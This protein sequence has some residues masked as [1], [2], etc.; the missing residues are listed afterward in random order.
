M[1]QNSSDPHPFLQLIFE[2]LRKP[3]ESPFCHVTYTWAIAASY[4]PMLKSNEIAH[5]V[6]QDVAKSLIMFFSCAFEA[7][8]RDGLESK[9][10][11]QPCRCL[12][13]FPGREL[14]EC[15]QHPGPG[16]ELQT[17]TLWIDNLASFI[18]LVAR[19]TDRLLSV[20]QVS[21]SGEV[22]AWRRRTAE[23]VEKHSDGLGQSFLI[24]LKFGQSGDAQIFALF[25]TMLEL[26]SKLFQQLESSEHLRL[27]WADRFQQ[28]IRTES[29]S[30]TQIRSPRIDL[31]FH[32]AGC[33]AEVALAQLNCR[34]TAY[35]RKPEYK[36]RFRACFSP[37]QPLYDDIC[38]LLSMMSKAGERVQNGGLEDVLRIGFF[39]FHLYEFLPS[40]G[41]PI[42][43]LITQAMERLPNLP[44][45]WLLFAQYLLIKDRCSNHLRHSDFDPSDLKPNFQY[46]INER[47]VKKDRLRACSGCKAN[48]Y[49]SKQ[50]QRE[51][52]NAVTLPHR[53][54]CP[55]LKKIFKVHEAR[56][57]TALDSEPTTQNPYEMA[58]ITKAEIGEALDYVMAMLEHFSSY[59]DWV[60]HKTHT[61]WQGSPR[62]R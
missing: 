61:K 33:V 35:Q 29:S 59:K 20:T 13:I 17:G 49:C 47:V 53:K 44:Q 9:L 10:F 27:A 19:F 15:H 41:L 57:N 36:S 54:I 28:L 51:S 5:P 26:E 50:C 32:G 16:V 3:L 46:A 11:R 22:R 7:A 23:L 21:Q 48:Y 55:V 18:T 1:A 39:G 42:S 31:I 34:T 40:K 56:E 60:S 6:M 14:V 37:I 8:T 2:S 62:Q 43:P 4:P 30:G 38:R 58:G 45:E 24:W 52:W 25:G 12:N